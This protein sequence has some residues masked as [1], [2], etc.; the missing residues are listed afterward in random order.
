MNRPSRTRLKEGALIAAAA[1]GMVQFV[2]SFFSPNPV[3]NIIFGL[4]I[5]LALLLFTAGQE[6]ILRPG[7]IFV[8]GFLW[9]VI[10]VI[11]FHQIRGT[12]YMLSGRTYD[13][14]TQEEIQMQKK[15]SEEATIEYNRKRA[16]E[17][18]QARANAEHVSKDFD[19]WS[20][21]N[22][23]KSL[24]G[25]RPDGAPRIVDAI[26]EARNACNY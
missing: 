4:V 16:I 23:L 20:E 13:G 2:S 3:A 6:D 15:R 18:E 5:T 1:I 12:I 10:V 25:Q 9:A 7:Y 22:A 21:E 14:V 17:C 19:A 26:K 24:A 8:G 11:S